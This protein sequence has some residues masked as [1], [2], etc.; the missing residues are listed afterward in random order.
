MPHDSVTAG[1]DQL[2]PELPGIARAAISLFVT[3]GE[4]LSPGRPG[5]PR[6]PVFVTLRRLDGALRGC[7]GTTVPVEVDVACETARNAVL[8]ATRDP[9]F[10]PVQPDELGLLSLDVSVLLPAEPVTDIGA[11][12]PARFG[13]VVSDGS[14][15]Q[16]VLLP[17]VP[18]VEDS[19]SQRRIACEKAGID[20]AG[21]V[22]MKR[23]R[24]LKFSESGP[25]SSSGRSRD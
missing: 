3:T 23:F 21:A 24:V 14:G 8:A 18:G 9:R 15:R 16:G 7:I 4:R 6:A 17:A 22:H 12:D 11:L 19:V 5:A 20:P 1:L 25:A 13:I 10:R 2:G